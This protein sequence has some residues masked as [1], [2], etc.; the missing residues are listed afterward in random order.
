[1]FAAY[2]VR[3]VVRGMDFQ[4]DVPV[5]FIVLALF[6]VALGIVSYMRHELRDEPAEPG[7]SPD[8][9]GSSKRRNDESES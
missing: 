1:V 6:V 8:P 4:P 3:S 7:E 2:I 5:D 9:A